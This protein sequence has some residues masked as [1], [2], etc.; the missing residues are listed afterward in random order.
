MNCS[1]TITHMVQSGDTF[2]NLAQFYQVPMELLLAWNPG[3]DPY[4]LQVGTEL[5]I[6]LTGGTVPGNPWESVNWQMVM[7]VS[8][9]MREAWIQHVYWTRMLLISI[10]D[11]LGDQTAVTVRLMENPA[12][13]AGVFARFYPP[14]VVTLLT[15]LLT[16]HLQI[17]GQLMVALRDGRRAEAARLSALWNNNADQMARAFASMSPQY[18]YEDVLAMLMRHL[19]LT[20]AEVTARLAGNYAADIQAFDQVEAQAL[21]MADYFTAGLVQ[22]FPMQFQ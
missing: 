2:Y 6:C 12:A 15:Q 11:R 20:T 22:Q 3:L 7:A 13:I 1:Q 14:Q 9:E 21:E 17:G 5:I 16:E 4:N 19:N 8:N 10:A 18:R